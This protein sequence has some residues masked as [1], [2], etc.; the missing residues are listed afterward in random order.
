GG[1]RCG[2]GSR[3]RAGAGK[4]EHGRFVLR[5]VVQGGGIEVGAV[6]PDERVRFAVEGDC[7]ELLEIAQGAVELAF[8]YGSKIDRA[9][10]AVFKFDPESVWA[11]DLDRPNAIDG[12]LHVATSLSKRLGPFPGGELHRNDDEILERARPEQRPV[13]F[14]NTNRVGAQEFED[15][16]EQIELG[17]FGDSNEGIR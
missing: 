17:L 3:G 7:V 4:G 5:P 2:G 12:V 9:D 10:E 1:S 8:E 6:G 14:A 16:I 11:R 15:S 13:V